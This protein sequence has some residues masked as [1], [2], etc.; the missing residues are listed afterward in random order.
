MFAGTGATAVG[1]PVL[2]TGATRVNRINSLRNNS[3]DSVYIEI[4]PCSFQSYFIRKQQYGL[5]LSLKF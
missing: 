5:K 3:P 2:I 4:A 1:I